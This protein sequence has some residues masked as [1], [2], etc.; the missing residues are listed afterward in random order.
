VR[1]GYAGGE[2]DVAEAE[3]G[4]TEEHRDD[5]C[6]RHFGCRRRVARCRTLWI[7]PSSQWMAMIEVS[8][9]EPKET[10]QIQVEKDVIKI[11]NK[12]HFAGDCKKK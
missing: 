1:P 12:S 7:T 11:R 5:A 3:R 6:G 9:P 4:E 8:P 10:L 2:S